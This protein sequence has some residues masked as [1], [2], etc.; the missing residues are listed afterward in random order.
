MA[1][2]LQIQYPDALDHITNRGNERKAIYKDNVDRREFLKILSQSM[3]T[4]GV[5]LHSFVLM[6]NHW[7]FLA[8]TPLE[9]LGEFMRHFNITYT[10]G[11][12]IR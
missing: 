2:P 7:H 6:N 12:I 4:Y 11:L 3:A 8:Q 5:V 10:S 9:N 1:R